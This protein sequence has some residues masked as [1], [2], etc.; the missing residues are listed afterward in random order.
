MRKHLLTATALAGFAAVVSGPNL[1]AQTPGPGYAASISGSANASTTAA[2]N[3]IAFNSGWNTSY[4]IYVTGLECGRTDTATTSV[5]VALNDSATTTIII[6]GA[7]GGGMVS[8][9]FDNPLV[10]AA[11]TSL[12]GTMSGATTSIYCSA[13]GFVAN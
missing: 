13:Q 4:K 1:S 12:T 3:I 8:F 7:A 5:R 6:P 11:D 9:R 2:F 10:V